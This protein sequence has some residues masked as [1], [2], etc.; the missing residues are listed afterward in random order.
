VVRKGIRASAV[1]IVLAGCQSV[2]LSEFNNAPVP[3]IVSPLPGDEVREGVPVQLVG[4][5]SDE[6]HALAE[7][8]VEWW[9]GGMRV[10]TEA[11]ATDGGATTCAVEIPLDQPV[12]EMVAIDGMGGSGSDA[13]ELNVLENVGPEATIFSPNMDLPHYAADD[14]FFDGRAVDPDDQPADLTTT[15]TSTLDGDLFPI[16]PLDDSGRAL[17]TRKL[18]AGEHVVRFEVVD[19]GGR[20]HWD[21]VEL[22]VQDANHAP[23]C[24]VDATAA[25][26]T[27]M[28]ADVV[29][30]ATISD[31]NLFAHP[32]LL[33]WT[34]TSDLE[35]LLAE[36]D[37]A[38]DATLIAPLRRGQHLLTLSADDGQGLTCTTSLHHTVHG[39]P[40][41]KLLAGPTLLVEGG[42]EVTIEVEATDEEDASKNMEVRFQSSLSGHLS[43]VQPKASGKATWTGTPDLGTQSLTATVTDSDGLS[44]ALSVSFEVDDCPSQPTLRIDPSSPSANDDLVAIASGSFDAEGS[45][46]TYNYVWLHNGKQAS[47]ADT[48]DASLTARGDT[49]TVQVVPT[50]GV[51][52][53]PMA[54]ASA[55]VGNVAP[56]LADVSITPTDPTTADSVFAVPGAASDHDGDSV[57][58]TYAWFV[59][60]VELPGETDLELLPLHFE[61]G[62]RVMVVATPN[63]GTTDGPDVHA[64]VTVINAAPSITSA[65]IQPA[66]PTSVDTLTVV[67]QGWS[68]LDGDVAAYTYAWEVNGVPVQQPS[69]QAT[70]D[71]SKF[72]RHDEVVVH[73]T[74]TDGI[75]DGLAVTSA[76]VVIG[77]GP[78]SLSGVAINPVDP[79]VGEEL[80][81]IPGTPSDP[82]GDAVT[83]TYQWSLNGVAVG[84]KRILDAAFTGGDVLVVTVTPNDGQVDGPSVSASVAVGNT[85]P[86]QPV[87]EI[88]P[89]DPTTVSDLRCEVVTPSYDDDGDLVTY[90]VSW[91]N[92]GQTVAGTNSLH[93]GD[94]IG[95][96]NTQAGEQWVCTATPSD[97]VSSGPSASA[98][99]LIKNTAPALQFVEISPATP[100]TH[101]DLVAVPSGW[102]DV[103]GDA[104]QLTYAWYDGTSSLIS[105]AA[106]L[107]H[108][109]TV[110]GIAYHVVVTPTDGQDPGAAV[111]SAE[112]LVTNSP[113]ML[114]WARITPGQIHAQD[115]LV[116]DIG[117]TTDADLDTVTVTLE[118]L[119]DG[120]VTDTGGSFAGNFV[121]GQTVALRATPHDGQVA[122]TALVHVLDVQNTA[123]TEPSVQ[124]AP[125]SPRTADDV[126]CEVVNPSV[127]A[128]GE[129][130]TYS[131][132]WTRNTVASTDAVDHNHVGDQVPAS[133]T[134]SH[135]TWECTATAHDGTAASPTGSASVTIDNTPPEVDTATITP[136]P[137][138]TLDTLVMTAAGSDSD[139]D[140]VN[141]QASWYRE[142]R[143]L[144]EPDPVALGGGWSL[145]STAFI[146]HDLVWAEVIA[147]DGEDD[148]VPLAA[149]AVVISNSPPTFSSFEVLPATP[150][151][152]EDLSV[153]GFGFADDDQDAEQFEVTWT[154][155]QLDFVSA[156]LPTHRFY[157]GATVQVTVR[158]FDGE[159]YSA[160]QS[161]TFEVENS[162]P[163]T[164]V[165]EVLPE[166]PPN[167]TALTCHRSTP[168]IDPD[169]DSVSY[170]FA[171]YVDG[172]EATWVTAVE[173]L[174]AGEPQPGEAWHCMA[175][176]TDGILFSDWATAA[177]VIIGTPTVTRVSVGNTVICLMDSASGNYCYSGLPESL[178]GYDPQIVPDPSFATIDLAA[179]GN[180]IVQVTDD[181]AAHLFGITGNAG[182]TAAQAQANLDSV[183][184]SGF[185]AVRATVGAVPNSGVLK[186]LCLTNAAGELRCVGQPGSTVVSDAPTEAVVDVAV[187]WEDAC[188]VT[189]ATG[190][191]VCWGT[192]AW[193]LNSDAP[194]GEGWQGIDASDTHMCV[195]GPSGIRCWGNN[196][197]LQSPSNLVT[198][199]YLDIAAGAGLS[200]A[201]D[202][203][204]NISWWGS[205]NFAPPANINNSRS[206]VAIS[207]QRRMS[208]ALD[209]EGEMLC[210][211]NDGRNTV[212][213][214]PTEWPWDMP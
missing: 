11:V 102:S 204:G 49:W 201:L 31:P 83:L 80:T 108:S 159:A 9:V 188:A 33:T 59:N 127:D 82:D 163:S 19:P 75:D 107:D 71:A 121:N 190:Q 3:V 178:E 168:S 46:I 203:F 94:L 22:L 110:K 98:S 17:G 72:A 30:P 4:T 139:G 193:N 134:Q 105:T 61:R 167:A 74:P 151:M 57:S 212:G 147:S 56:A 47:S 13:V 55:T 128:D 123:P 118:W 67:E 51:C 174:P 185:H 5:V 58:V 35:G 12:V 24:E 104:M 179:G 122:G 21:E 7:V 29:I 206:W 186:N 2:S 171:W 48:V 37:L 150:S 65:D 173:E 135:E 136:E 87:V 50:D 156:T 189:V 14:I 96:S 187:A 54:E 60:G 209:T 146:K 114:S 88:N 160:P 53:G 106:T 154:V 183:F 81:A 119:V 39:P 207:S 198:G 27:Q 92:S 115:H 40:E 177:P 197:N 153:N 170:E 16:Q 38:T 34:W 131:M 142:P 140:N 195:R 130:L 117:P 1:C 175:R 25:N 95:A 103:D 44:A 184:S 133:A 157:S 20:M 141:L 111:T 23:L 182:W 158:A 192:D 32:N 199:R 116:A 155:D 79:D 10:C 176:A 208:C 62:D 77:N 86:T 125:A 200:I 137:A 138:Y 120:V 149:D 109:Q 99:T 6:D 85:P 161:L 66:P 164:P 100:G 28:G 93:L 180:T 181:G 113:P 69:T 78:P 194:A 172:F 210:W 18:T 191:L 144:N 45:A 148:S 152:S 70:L 101:D 124:I 143:D 41:I 214:T 162:A 126:T 26:R 166:T 15:W 52:D 205:N 211:G 202:K 68:D 97:Q 112:V 43:T 169:G 132:T 8:F 213:Q 91:S 90:V 73:V 76:S 64:E 84:D 42:H 129:L 63:D 165:I 145:S 196:Q 36:G 89:V